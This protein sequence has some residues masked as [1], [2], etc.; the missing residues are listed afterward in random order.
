MTA[1]CKSCRFAE[2]ERTAKGHI[3]HR[4][5]GKCRWVFP[6]IPVPTSMWKAGPG[7]LRGG[8]INR[9]YNFYTDCPTW[10]PKQP[11]E[12]LT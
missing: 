11:T 10:E 2:W 1:D 4:G 8:N 7:H 3:N 9:H 12:K 6:N 5:Y